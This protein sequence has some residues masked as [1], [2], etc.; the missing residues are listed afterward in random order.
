MW[1]LGLS[2]ADRNT[3]RASCIIGGPN[4]ELY[5]AHA[6]VYTT[7]C[8]NV[9]AATGASIYA[10]DPNV[11]TASTAESGLYATC[12]AGAVCAASTTGAAGCLVAADHVYSVCPQAGCPGRIEKTGTGGLLHA[13]A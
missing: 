12:C 5:A 4:G 7:A 3:G 11:Y 9:F 2:I 10:T 1:R 6:N 8:A 13:A